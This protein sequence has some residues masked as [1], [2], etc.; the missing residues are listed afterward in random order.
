MKKKFQKNLCAALVLLALFALW[1]VTVRYVDVQA[2]GPD[3]SD[4]G[5]ADLNGFFH[6]LTGVHMPLYTITDWLGLVPLCFV[7]GFA[8]LGLVQLIKRKSL[9]KVDFSILVLGGFYIIV[10]AAYLLF[11]VLVINYRPVLIDGNLE[12][13]YPS[14]TTMLVMCVIPTAIMQ[15]NT[16]ISNKII[17]NVINGILVVFTVFMVIGRLLSGVH[18]LSDIVGGVLLSAGLVILYYSLSN[19]SLKKD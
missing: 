8:L 11:E 12:A 15:F 18:W 2:I 7:L 5:F 17:K 16:R 9:L 19:L 14:S 13:S 1:T 4:V 3:G 6:K 10:M